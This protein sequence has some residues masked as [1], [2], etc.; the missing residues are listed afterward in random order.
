M[1]VVVDNGENFG[2]EGRVMWE[3]RCVRQHGCWVLGDTVKG[4]GKTNTGHEWEWWVWGG[5]LRVCVCVCGRKA[6]KKRKERK[7]SEK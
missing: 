2:M 3:E 4:N 6:R 1:N 5:W 7:T